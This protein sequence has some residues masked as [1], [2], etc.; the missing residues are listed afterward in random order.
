MVVLSLKMKLVSYL[1]D[2]SILLVKAFSYF[3]L[4]ILKVFNLV[5][6]LLMKIKYG[7][8]FHQHLQNV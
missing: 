7:N 2:Y 8:L 6:L 4:I 3:H 1:I 5:L